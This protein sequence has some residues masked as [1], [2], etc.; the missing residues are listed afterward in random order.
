MVTVNMDNANSGTFPASAKKGFGIP[1]DNTGAHIR[2]TRVQPGGQVPIRQQP[3][4]QV[5]DVEKEPGKYIALALV[6]IHQTLAKLPVMIED[7]AKPFD[8]YN[9][10]TLAPEAE[11]QLTLQPQW[12]V[13]EKVESIMI[14]G[15]AGTVTLQLG[16]RVWPLTIPAA[17]F[18]F[19]GA[20]LAIYLGR[21]DLRILTAQT[22]GEYTLELM[23]HCDT[24]GNLI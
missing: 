23:G 22:P 8:E 24:R 18:I 21:D 14:T 15:P 9:N 10:Q 16:D 19:I 17:G 6:R 4:I 12:E 13:T 3:P 11:T 2:R 5:P 20:P 7:H 1:H